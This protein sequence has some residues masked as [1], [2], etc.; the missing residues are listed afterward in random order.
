M[1][2][3]SSQLGEIEIE[4]NRVVSFPGGIPG[5]EK[6]REYAIFPI[7]KEGPFYYMHALK[8]PDLCLVLA[9][10]FVFFPDYE[11]EL[12][13]ESLEIL[14]VEN[15]EQELAV[16]SVLTIPGDFKETTANLLAPVVINPATRKGLQYVAVN[17]DYQ[18]KHRIFPEQQEANST[19]GQEL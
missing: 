10:P 17:A 11:L 5:F 19:E 13:S 4:E 18:T 12:S 15:K 2:L 9:V 16:F 7:D 3:K 14:G 1:I 8:N 6:D